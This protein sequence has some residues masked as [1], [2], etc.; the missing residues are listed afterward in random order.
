MEGF[1]ME[2]FE[3]RKKEPTKISDVSSLLEMLKRSRTIG[4]SIYDQYGAL[5][6][7]VE[8]GDSAVEPLI[9]A[10]RTDKDEVAR[11]AAAEALGEIGDKRAVEPLIETLEQDVHPDVRW[12]A[13]RALGEIGYEKLVDALG[14]TGYK[15]A[16]KSLTEASKDDDSWVRSYAGSALATIERERKEIEDT[17][18]VESLIKDWKTKQKKDD[19]VAKS[20]S[21]VLR[22]EDTTYGSRIKALEVLEEMQAIR[23]LAET[24]PVVEDKDIKMKLLKFLSQAQSESV[25]PALTQVLKA[26]GDPSVRLKAAE[27]LGKIGSASSVPDLIEALRQDKNSGVRLKSAEALG[28]IG[29]SSA[30]PALTQALSDKDPGVQRKATKA[31]ER[32]KRLAE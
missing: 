17:R 27:V 11:W 31:I 22:D 30:I 20:L 26:D 18:K 24:L 2:V 5:D 9:K 19:E 29:D 32:L 28:R 4:T 15:K 12:H 21:C 13:A 6:R 16:V 3:F 8:L 25:V 1:E 14:Q 10:L 7:L 23:P